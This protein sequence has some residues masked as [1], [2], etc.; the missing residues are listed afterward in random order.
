MDRP[1]AI[2]LVALFLVI[3]VSSRP[4]AA[5]NALPPNWPW[6]GVVVMSMTMPNAIDMQ[7]LKEIGV[8]VVN[9]HLM[10]RDSARRNKI[11]GRK[12]FKKDLKW[13]GAFLSECKVR[14]ITA[15]ISIAQIP[16]DPA[17]GLTQTSPGFWDDPELLKEAVYAAGELARLFHGRGKELAAYSILSEPVVIRDNFIF[18][19]TSETPQA[20]PGLMRDIVK[21]IRKYDK[22]RFISVTPGLWGLPAGYEGFKPLDDPYIIY[23]AHMYQPHYFTHQGIAERPVGYMYPGGVLWWSFK[24]WD[25]EALRGVLNPLIEFER[26]YN[27][28]V[29]IGEFSAARWAE[30]G[31]EYLYDLINIFDSNGLAWAYHCFNCW[32]GWNPDYADFADLGGYAAAANWRLDYRGRDTM[33]WRL[34]KAAFKN[35]KIKGKIAR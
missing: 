29:W 31:D 23:E 26:R 11:S 18:G 5:S 35:N 30:G 25:E 27:V 32:H 1:I 13:L 3:S 7:Y 20:W 24:Y 17:T 15:V 16:L 8:N 21:E 14:G 4:V 9:I 10:S 33:R 12:A 34:L 6:R 28:P 19:A 2:H 22:K